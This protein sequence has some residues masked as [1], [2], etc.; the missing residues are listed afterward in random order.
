MK[1][2][3]WC[4]LA[5]VVS[6]GFPGVG[7]T[8]RLDEYLQATTITLEHDRVLFHVRLTP[9]VDVAEQIIGQIDR[10]GDMV[11]SPDE[12]TAYAKKIARNLSVS[13]NG[14]RTTLR[15]DG[16]AFPA[17]TLLRAGTGV[18][19]LQFDLPMHMTAGHY[20]LTYTNAATEPDVVHLVN[21]L[22]P[23]DPAVHVTGQKRSQDQS[24][25]RLD[26]TVMDDRPAPH[27]TQ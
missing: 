14:K 1:K 27:P 5:I 22:V 15:F 18:V 10:N 26:F 19:E 12:Q 20:R 17:T 21:C 3:I 4:A 8:H 13:L 7:M 16:G 24:V 11:L 2:R 25:Y 9:G 23:Q 6:T